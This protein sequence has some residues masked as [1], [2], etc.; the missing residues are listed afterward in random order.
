M[1]SSDEINNSW[2]LLKAMKKNSN[3]LPGRVPEKTAR[4]FN[5]IVSSLPGVGIGDERFLISEHDFFTITTVTRASKSGLAFETRTN[6]TTV[7]LTDY[8]VKLD[9][10]L[11]LFSVHPLT[12]TSKIGF[13]TP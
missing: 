13:T 4:E 5:A 2:A 11:L 8:L 9:A 1:I 7:A 12:G 6:P 10:I 3:R